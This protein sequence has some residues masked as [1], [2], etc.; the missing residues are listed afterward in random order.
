MAILR[1][2]YLKGASQKLGGVV[3]YQA[4]GRTLARELAPA[5]SN[6]R[7]PAQ[8]EQRVKLANV[9]AVYRANRQW[10]AGS[11]EDKK[12]SESDYN[13][14]VSANLANSRVATSKSEAAAGAAVASPYKVTSGSL[15]SIEQQATTS[16]ITTNL[17]LGALNITSSTTIGALS[18][19]LINNNNAIREGM[20]LSLVI[21][22]QTVDEYTNIPYIVVRAHEMII[23][24]NSAE[25]LTDYIPGEIVRATG[26]ADNRL[27]FD[28]SSL[29]YGS[30]TFILSETISGR[31]RV[32]TQS[33]LMFGDNPTYQFYTSVLAWQQAVDSYGVG[34]EEFL[35]S[36]SAS[37]SSQVE[38]QNSI[39]A[40]EIN[41]QQYTAGAQVPGPIAA[42]STIEISLAQALPEG[43][44]PTI[45]LRNLSSNTNV[46]LINTQV[47][48]DRLTIT[49]ERNSKYSV[50]TTSAMRLSVI[51]GEYI[52]SFNFYL[53]NGDIS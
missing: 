40:V 39:T 19:A 17:Y 1:S 29:G 36:A 16:A 10:M 50:S 9:V 52:F 47:S 42:Q 38:V 6:P 3:L 45:A 26:S 20:Q 32:S 23:N 8:M 31:T 41:E 37:G 53:T 30:A 21:N 15:P 11:F 49:C 18:A 43:Q 27:Y 25:L 22:I 51:V 12:Q 5:V 34:V 7:T 14:F 46:P 44:T 24:S 33:M 35:S 28:G 4:Q 2:I 13:A 48:A